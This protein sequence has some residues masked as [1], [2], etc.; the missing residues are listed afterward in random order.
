MDDDLMPN[1]STF[2]F[3]P[4]E[5]KDQAIARKK[6]RA[7]TLKT[8]DELKKIVHHFDERIKYRDT[9][10]ALNVN[11]KEDPELHQKKCEVNEMLKLALTE[12]KN[13]LEELID[14]HAKN[15]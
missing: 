4:R 2:Y 10:E 11:L 6:E 3:L 1:D 15:R 12:E 14:I 5:P 8:L 13:L 9:I 7:E